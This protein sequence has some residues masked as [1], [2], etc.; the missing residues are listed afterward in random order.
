MRD[1]IPKKGMSRF[2]GVMTSRLGLI[3]LMAFST[4]T[5]DLLVQNWNGAE[6]KME[7]QLPRLYESV[8][9]KFRRSLSSLLGP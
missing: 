6:K 7:Q 1:S 2:W 3:V 4:L 9:G 8:D 5:V